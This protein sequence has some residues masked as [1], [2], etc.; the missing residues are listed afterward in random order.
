MP[1]FEFYTWVLGA[2]DERNLSVPESASVSVG[3]PFHVHLGW[4]NLD[5]TARWFGQLRYGGSA[6]RTFVTVN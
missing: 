2:R 4:K 6:D 1:P 5:P 3:A